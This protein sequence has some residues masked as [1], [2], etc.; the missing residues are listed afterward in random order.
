M[1]DTKNA[2][3]NNI[4]TKIRS[5][6]VIKLNVRMLGR[7]F[8]GFLAI[9]VLIILMGFF[10]V[11][12]KAEEGA[13]NII[14]AIELAPNNLQS[15]Y[16]DF[17]NY[18]ILI[19]EG[20]LKGIK[21]PRNIQKRLP[22]EI[23]DAKRS[24]RVSRINKE[25]KL[26][27][28]IDLVKY[29]IELSI[30]DTSYQ[31]IYGLGRDLRLFLH[32]FLIVLIYELLIIVGDI[33]KGSR[34]IRKTLKPL[35]DLTETAK[36]LNAEVLS[37]G[38]NA[39]GTHIKDLAGVISS[40]D[41]NKLDKR[42]S[43]DS[44]QNELKDLAYA[45]NDMLNRIN[46]SYQ[47][48]VRFVSDASHELRTPIS[49]IQGY[50]NL[51][52][53]W[54]K[55]DERTMQE[56]IDAIKSETENM[57]E[58]VEQLLFLARGDN[59]TIQLHKEG[60]DACEV[61]GEIIRETQMIDPNHKFEIDLNRP[62]YI[63]A[64]K[65][66]IKQAIRILVDNSIKYT[67]PGKKIILRVAIEED[68]V[69]IIVQDSGIGIEPEYLPRIFDRFYRSDESRARKTGGSGLGLS[70]AKWIIERHGAYFEILS[71]VDVG[72]RITI[73]MPASKMPSSE[74]SIE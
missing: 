40:I 49:V 30:N 16:Y 50:V 67:P 68:S 59:E 73:V 43:V 58:L 11:L 47:S 46:D 41:A 23:T 18:Q 60:F 53:R 34:I 33:G 74:M 29:T 35:S 63:N 56:S 37:M 64:D 13:K 3:S 65:Q 42:I 66:L 27:E 45:I 21:L 22:L 20:P 14:T 48:Q 44:S 61:V 6:L 72:T 2:Y 26:L 38:T 62:A 8:S 4:T 12:W 52:D 69:R 15:T 25:M 31:I 24:I 51:L 19:K 1:S 71:R 57:K 32:L 54:G 9:N 28:K 7:L 5:S 17:K 70:I 55:K 10:V 36:N 39:D